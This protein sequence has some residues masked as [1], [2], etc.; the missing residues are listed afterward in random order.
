MSNIS[1]S[2]YLP[3]QVALLVLF[4]GGI[5]PTLPLWL[6]FLPSILLGVVWL[7]CLVILIV[8]AIVASR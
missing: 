2:F 1:I 7:I 6:V 8:A 3:V 5:M 4:Y